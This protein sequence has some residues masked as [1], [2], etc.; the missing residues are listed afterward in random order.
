MPSKLPRP[1]HEP[2]GDPCK[3][4]GHPSVAHRL[5]Q[6]RGSRPN[7]AAGLPEQTM[8]ERTRYIGIDGE[9]MDGEGKYSHRYTLLA[10]T[11]RFGERRW[12]VEAHPGEGLTTVE[13]L[14]MILSLPTNRTKVFSYSFNYDLTMM[15]RDVD[16]KTLYKLFHTESRKD[17]RGNIVGI[18]WGKYTLNLIGTK[19]NIKAMVNDKMKS[20]TVWDLFRFYA[21]KFVSALQ[22]WKVGTEEMITRMSA[23]KD[24]R[25]DFKTES[26]EAI[27]NYC[28]EECQCIAELGYRLVTAHDKAGLKLTKYYGAGSSGEAM[29][30]AM[31]IK[32]RTCS[33]PIQM[34]KVLA[35][36][37][38]GGR[39]EN[40]VIGPIKGPLYAWDISSAYPYH[41]T[42]L[43]CLEHGEWRHTTDRAE[44]EGA[45]AACVHYEL[46]ANHVISDWGPFPFR[47]ETGCIS[48]PTHSGGGWIW[49]E[50]YLAGER[51]FPHVRMREAWVYHTNCTCK[52]FEKIPHYYLERIKLGKEGPGIVIKLGVN[53]CYGKLAQSVGSAKFNNWIWA[54]MITSGCRAQILDMLALHKDRKNL[55]MVATDGIVTREVLVPPTARDTGTYH[56]VNSKGVSCPLGGWEGKTYPKGM[57]FARPGIYFPLNPTKDDLADVKARGLGKKV[58]FDQ[59][60]HIVKSWKKYGADRKVAIAHIRRF[61]GAKSSLL[62][63]YRKGYTRKEVYGQWTVLPVNMSFDPMPK[64]EGVNHDGVTLQLRRFPDTKESVPYKKA[65]LS[66][67]AK[68]LQAAQ[69]SLSEQPEHD[70]ESA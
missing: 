57:F 8:R 58:L 16:D 55:L 53:S 66:Q 35:S 6:P 4:C 21:K 15:L 20:V 3:K 31:G 45:Q 19:F 64:R 12:S 28:F 29:L 54:G 65:V 43:P 1:E 63:N 52:P 7:R 39:F 70:Y 30:V 5:R 13:C 47:D 40:S 51:A 22:D 26:R 62:F 44:I 56:A 59:W 41:T 10:A 17:K 38:F 50:E 68:E 27:R 67:E 33:Y 69:N 60:K 24:K 46:L 32:E 2:Q 36:A 48:F 49:K 9:G 25:A 34:R 14:D 23:M 42:T 61:N 11:D 37:F 18:A